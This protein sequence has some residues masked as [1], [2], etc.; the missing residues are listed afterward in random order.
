MPQRECRAV[1]RLFGC[2]ALCLMFVTVIGLSGWHW[3]S[4]PPRSELFP[5]WAW[6]G[7]SDASSA[8]E[9]RIKSALARHGILAGC[10]GTVVMCYY[11]PTNK[12]VQA[13]LVLAFEK[14]KSWRS[15]RSIE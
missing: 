1:R 11:V 6:V 5:G 3:V 4:R 8:K 9:T 7:S 14:L 13:R 10:E 12:L 15:V 2:A